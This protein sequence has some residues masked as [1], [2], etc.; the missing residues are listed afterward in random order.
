MRRASATLLIGMLAAITTACGSSPE[1]TTSGSSSTAAQRIASPAQLVIT[2]PKDGAVVTGGTV[3]VEVQVIGAT[4]V[5][6][7]SQDISPT[8]GH[9]HLLLDGVLTYMSYT[10]KQDIPVNHPGTYV[11]RA[12][13]VASDHAPFNPRVMSAQVLFTVP[14]G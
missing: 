3:H 13:F 1:P 8:Q 7:T 2:T 12:E 5:Q 6:Q 11:L 10:L 9:V 4:V 14:S